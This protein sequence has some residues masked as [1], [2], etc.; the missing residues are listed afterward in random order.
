MALELLVDDHPLLS[1]A[2]FVATFPAPLEQCPSPPELLA[3]LAEDPGVDARAAVELGWSEGPPD[4]T[5]RKAVR[6]LLRQG[7]FRPSGRSKPASEFLLKAARGHTLGSINLAVDLCNV[8][9]LHAGVPISV[10]D[11]ERVAA[12]LRVGVVEAGEYVFNASGQVIKIDGLLCLQDGAG[13][14]ANP[15]KDS[16]RS[17]THAGTRRTLCVV[18]GATALGARVQAAADWYAALHARCG[19]SVEKAVCSTPNG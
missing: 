6:D 15:V 1:L 17:K 4:D 12:P 13:P 10:V 2:A 3:A 9:S 5:L 18:W 16:Q 8:A 7:G 14:C 19:A 11:L